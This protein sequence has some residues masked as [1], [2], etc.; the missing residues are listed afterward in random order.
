MSNYS[1]YLFAVVTVR[2]CCNCTVWA[3][4]SSSPSE[5]NELSLH[6]IRHITTICDFLRE[7]GLCHCPGFN[8]HAPTGLTRTSVS[9]WSCYTMSKKDPHIFSCYSSKHCWILTILTDIY[10]AESRQLKNCLF[11]LLHVISVFSRNCI[12]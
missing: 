7:I 9:L 2:F 8:A 6:V 11:S 4:S 12:F 10:F 3:Q 1:D 5:Q